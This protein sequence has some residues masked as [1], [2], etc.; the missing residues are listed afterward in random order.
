[1]R[2]A[3]AEI[4]RHRG[5]WAS[6]IGA[7]A[8]IVFLVLVLAALADGLFVGMTGALGTGNTDALVYSADG[9]RSLVRSELPTS[10]LPSV[11]AVE[12]VADV[13]ALGLL[14]ATAA[15]DADPF[16]IAVMGHLPGHAGEPKNLVEG[17]RPE[18]REPF[19]GLA[20]VSLRA[21]GISLGDSV[22]LTGS[23]HPVEVVGFVEDARYLLADTLWV[24]ME[25][26]E[27]LRFEIRPE[28]VGLGSVVQAFPILVSE[29][30]GVAE[31]A[32]AVDRAL[33]ITETVTTDEAILS[34]PGVEQQQSTFT[35]II[36]VS[37]VVVGIVIALFF[38]LIT[39][40]KRGQ[41]AILK[42]IGSSNPFLLRGLVVQALIATMGGYVL[43]FGLSRLLAL[44]LPSTVPVAFRSST[45]LLLFLATVAMGALGAVFSFRRII[46]IDPASALGGEA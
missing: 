20:D 15:T 19:V 13:G 6:I 40:E 23:S 10:D 25:T 36:M 34:L 43:G 12:G 44:A 30:A 11:A 42:A 22:T 27:A 1:M 39:L 28:T 9:R 3:L 32:A 2:L 38:A 5:R 4:L 35:A 8:F 17:R 21:E 24:S 33:T 14:L 41:F 46:R 18:L 37:F 31:V 7:V 45:A 26:W 16:D 29:G